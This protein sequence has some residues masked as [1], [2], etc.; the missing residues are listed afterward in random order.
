MRKLQT[1]GNLN[2]RSPPIALDFSNKNKK[3][4]NIGGFKMIDIKKS[5]KTAYKIKID[6][7]LIEVSEKIYTEYHRMER[8]ERYLEERDRTHGKFLYSDMNTAEITGEEMI[9]DLEAISV[10]DNAIN[11]ALVKQLCECLR[12]LTN[13]ERELIDT[14]FFSNDGEGVSERDYSAKSGIPQK[15]INDRKRKIFDKLKKLLK[16]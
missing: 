10:E 7:Q 14:L 6:G 16:I 8:R 4:S 11:R 12:L 2:C 9:P 1:R 3:F 13:D 5:K 15:T